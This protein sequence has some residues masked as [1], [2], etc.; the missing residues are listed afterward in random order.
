MTTRFNLV[1]AGAAA[2][3]MTV[4]AATAQAGGLMC[5]AVSNESARLADEFKSFDANGDGQLSS[6]EYLAE[7][8]LCVPGLGKEKTFLMLDANQDSQLSIDEYC[9]L[10]W[11]VVGR[12]CELKHSPIPVDTAPADAKTFA[13][14]LDQETLKVSPPLTGNVYDRDSG[15][16]INALLKLARQRTDGGKAAALSVKLNPGTATLDADGDGELTRRECWQFLYAHNPE[17]R[18]IEKATR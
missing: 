17:S 3:L 6:A 15:R 9:T 16:A 11:H 12:H 13:D 1:A 14:V 4:A 8:T 2:V 7:K 18:V 10:P 5:W